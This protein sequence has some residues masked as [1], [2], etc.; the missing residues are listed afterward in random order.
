MNQVNISER[1][2]T[3]T[4][5]LPILAWIKINYL[6]ITLVNATASSTLSGNY[7]RESRVTDVISTT[8]W[9]QS[10]V[11][12]RAIA[13]LTLMY[14]IVHGVVDV[15]T[16][17][18]CPR[19]RHTCHTP[20]MSISLKLLLIFLFPLHNLWMKLVTFDFTQ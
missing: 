10:F 17:T 14:K 2:S 6:I 4:T 18:L 1:F 7:N 16:A 15:W 8:R 11:E 12:W 13:H 19:G 3:C 9:Q 20:H 5:V